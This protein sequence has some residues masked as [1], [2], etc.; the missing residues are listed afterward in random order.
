MKRGLEDADIERK[1]LIQKIA[2]F[3]QKVL[4]SSATYA[5]QTVPPAIPDVRGIKSPHPLPWNKYCVSC[6][7]L[8]IES[9]T[10]Q[11]VAEEE[12]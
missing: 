4:P 12:D 6:F 10:H 3:L 11:V 8:R 2:E 5:G 9:F 7:M 1:A